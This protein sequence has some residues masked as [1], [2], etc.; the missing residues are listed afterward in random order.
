MQII[1]GKKFEE[2]KEKINI[3]LITA[4]D[5]ERDEVNNELICNEPLNKDEKTVKH[6]KKKRKRK[7]ASK[8]LRNGLKVR[9]VVLL[10]LTLIVNTYAWFIYIST[11]TMG[12]DVHV[13]SWKI[14]FMNDDSQEEFD[15]ILDEVYPGMPDAT[16]EITAKNSGEMD[17]TLSCK[18]V[19][20]Q[21]FDE[22]FAISDE[23]EGT[24]IT[25]EEILNKLKEYPFDIKIALQDNDITEVK[26]VTVAPEES[27]RIKLNVVWPYETGETETEILASDI[28]RVLQTSVKGN[29][30]RDFDLI[31]VVPVMFKVDD[32]KTRIPRGFKGRSL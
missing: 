6:K 20:M 21:I 14:D 15:L 32:R 18:I 25:E 23:Y 24:V 8:K 2:L 17:A 11:V 22:K 10:L 9:T 12:V 30:D 27:I 7:I 28:V 29:I 4:A 16:Q 5:C 31:T 13:K 3:L 26:E 1:Y 19:A